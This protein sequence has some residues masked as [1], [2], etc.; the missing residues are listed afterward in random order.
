MTPTKTDQE[1]ETLTAH[2]PLEDGQK[3]AQ[4][5]ALDLPRPAGFRLN[6][7][8]ELAI[9]LAGSKR[10]EKAFLG[11]DVKTE[12]TEFDNF[13]LDMVR[14]SQVVQASAHARGKGETPE[15]MNLALDGVAALAPRDGLEV[16]LCSQL[17]ALHSQ[18]MEFLRRGMLDDQTTDGVDRN[19]NR[20][21]KL[22]RAFATIN[23]SLR[24]YRGGGQQKMTVEHVTVQAGGQAIV[25]PVNRGG[26]E[27]SEK[28]R[29]NP[30]QSGADG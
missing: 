3:A 30:M 7:K 21:T 24:T 5:K 23:E 13:S 9:N 19:V 27:C 12:H 11:S 29:M 14:L 10:I 2:A 1:S 28:R 4:N 22:L 17:V 20:A 18:S 8:G 16:L 25:G 6:D 15:A 26:G